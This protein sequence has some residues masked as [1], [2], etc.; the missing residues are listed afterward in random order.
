MN[1]IEYSSGSMIKIDEQKITTARTGQRKKLVYGVLFGDGK[2][3]RGCSR[4]S[5][6]Y[7]NTNYIRGHKPKW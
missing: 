5:Q 3:D 1:N 4:N 2:V 7:A 6:T